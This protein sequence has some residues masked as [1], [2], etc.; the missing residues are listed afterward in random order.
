[1]WRVYVCVPTYLR[2]IKV[3]LVK[4]VNHHFIVSF[5]I[6]HAASLSFARVRA[7]VAHFLESALAQET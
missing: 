1:M 3:D 2:D 4:V 5:K 7:T 6:H